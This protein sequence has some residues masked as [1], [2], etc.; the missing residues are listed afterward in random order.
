MSDW[1]RTETAPE[2]VVV[3][4]KI[5]DEHGP[6]NETTLKRIRGLWWAPDQGMYV[7]YAPTHWK[8]VDA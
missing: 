5:D 1:Q 4:T 8:P 2:D 3:M 7:Y 6:R